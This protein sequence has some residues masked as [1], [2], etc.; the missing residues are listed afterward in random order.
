MSWSSL[1]WYGVAPL[2][3]GSYGAAFSVLRLRDG[4]AVT[5]GNIASLAAGTGFLVLGLFFTGVTIWR[6]P[7]SRGLLDRY[8]R[9]R[10]DRKRRQEISKWQTAKNL[11]IIVSKREGDRVELEP[12][13]IN[14]LNRPDGL[15][16]LADLTGIEVINHYSR[17]VVVDRLWL[18]T[19][20][21]A[22]GEEI[23]PS[24]T[25][26]ETVTGDIL[27]D[28]NECGSF[29]LHLT[30]YIAGLIRPSECEV[31]LVVRLVERGSQRVRITPPF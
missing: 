5:W 10:L 16:M 19:F 25:R 11:E 22:T 2:A 26:R 29:G 30:V 23:R 8:R 24:A 13:F 15:I 21:P 20:D 4:N 31:F 17:P 1:S 18:G 3:L 6:L 9:W 28:A 27:I 12:I 14:A 7:V